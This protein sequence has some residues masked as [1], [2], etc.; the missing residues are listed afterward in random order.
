M[1][2]SWHCF[3]KALKAQGIS[4]ESLPFRGTNMRFGPY[5]AL[6]LMM[7]LMLTS[8]FS[9]FTKGNW[10]I[11]DFICG[12]FGC[13][14]KILLLQVL[15]HRTHFFVDCDSGVLCGYVLVVLGHRQTT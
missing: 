2:V 7:I 11:Q 13:T 9:V 1:L 3:Q 12:Y 14:C 5:V 10:D 6:T 4:R 8:A 15:V